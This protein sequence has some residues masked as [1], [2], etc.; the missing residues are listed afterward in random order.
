MDGGL[1]DRGLIVVT[2]PDLR[3]R[4]ARFVGALA[5]GT[6]RTFSAIGSG[7]SSVSGSV[8][9]F[10]M[11]WSSR[12]SY[13][14]TMLLGRTNIDYAGEVVD[15]T[16]N[17]IVVAVVGWIARNFPEAPVRVAKVAA[18]GTKSYIPEGLTGAGWFLRLME[19]PN[20]YFSGV[21]LWMATIVDLYTTGNAYWLKIR[22][23]S[24]RV[25]ELWWV[26]KKFMRPAW[27]ADGSEFITAYIYTPNSEPMLVDPNDV[28]H[29]RDGI[30][31]NNTR[32]GLSKLA[33][34]FREI[35]TD[36]EA[37]NFSAQLL[38]NLGVPG[39]VIAP[40]NTA[41]S[42]M[43]TDPEKIKQA[44]MEKFGGDRRGEPLVLTSPTDVKVLSFSPDQ[45][46]LRVLRQ[47]P[48]ERV[49]AVLGVA[50]SVAGLGAGLDRNTFTNYGEARQAAYE[51]SVIPM[52]RLISAEL[53]VQ[54]LDEFVNLDDGYAIDFDLRNV[55][56]LAEDVDK[57]WTRN[58][59][60]ATTGLLMR[61]DFLRA[62]GDE[63]ATD[64]SDDVYIYPNNY[65]V[66]KAD[67]MSSPGVIPPAALPTMPA[68]PA[69]SSNGH[70]RELTGAAP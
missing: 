11:T 5:D 6:R 47:I 57:I 9:N 62:I 51:E 66:V 39:V 14:L 20:D 17:S 4:P 69:G 21:L 48:E 45:M 40:S 29:F 52:Q 23:E 27:P 67:D 1:V 38:A 59:R 50:A 58:I 56:A 18:D 54:L 36:D 2:P 30:D 3:S 61:S 8:R 43:K 31:P 10:S 25:T 68:L 19:R 70:S 42:G 7:I 13:G 15:P 60:A 63:P 44:F 37:A 28:V 12:A 22:S 35:Y 53:K 26:P 49:S 33:S 64:G 16:H 65:S 34:L 24:G 46:N 55:R 41:P 32:L